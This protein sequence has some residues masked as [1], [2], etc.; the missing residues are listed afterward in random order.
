MAHLCRRHPIVVARPFVLWIL[1]ILAGAGAGL[2][3]GPPATRSIVDRAAGVLVLVATLYTAWR[4][5]QWWFARYVITDRRI[6]LVEGIVSRTISAIPLS[7]ITDTTFRRS[8]LGRM[9]RYGD[10]LLDAPGER[11]GLPRL[12]FLPKPDVAYRL[13]MGLVNQPPSSA[14]RLSGYPDATGP[15]PWRLP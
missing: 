15:I 5:A 2:V 14:P 11:P 1:A 8:P 13:I 3:L 12:T 9:L 4:A 7:K 6:L 10:L